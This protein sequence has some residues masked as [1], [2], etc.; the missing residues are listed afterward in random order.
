MI[1][2]FYANDFYTVTKLWPLAR[3]TGVSGRKSGIKAT[4]QISRADALA[5]DT[6]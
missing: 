2:G 4:G 3:E 1:V 5:D 6:A